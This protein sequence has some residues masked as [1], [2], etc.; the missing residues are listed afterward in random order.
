MFLKSRA[1]RSASPRPSQRSLR[2]TGFLTQRSQRKTQRTER[3]K[4][5]H[6]HQFG[7]DQLPK[8]DANQFAGMVLSTNGFEGDRRNFTRNLARA[9][10]ARQARICTS[11]ASKR[12][13]PRHGRNNDVFPLAY[14]GAGYI[15]LIHAFGHL[16]ANCRILW[17]QGD[18]S[19]ISRRTKIIENS[20]QRFG[21]EV[22]QNRI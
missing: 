19:G 18:K 17:S 21:H 12:H 8:N 10:I 3:V 7:P 15:E 13:C 16:K 22:E 5:H 14:D 4:R 6:N 9:G 1:P 20:S 2:L 11:A